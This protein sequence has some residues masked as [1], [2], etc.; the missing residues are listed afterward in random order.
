MVLLGR[1]VD[2]VAL[3]AADAIIT[4]SHLSHKGAIGTAK[5]VSATHSQ[6]E[7]LDYDNRFVVYTI[8]GGL[9]AFLIGLIAIA[10]R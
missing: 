2:F 7:T 4:A 3:R 1:G 10:F 6:I 9:D 5:T 8:L